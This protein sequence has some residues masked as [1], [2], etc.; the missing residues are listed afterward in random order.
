MYKKRIWGLN[1]I[2]L[3]L[4]LLAFPMGHAANQIDEAVEKTMDN[5]VYGIAKLVGASYTR[6]SRFSN[7][8][9]QWLKDNGYQE[10]LKHR[11]NWSSF[12]GLEVE[13][14]MSRR[15]T[16]FIH[17]NSDTALGYEE[18]RGELAQKFTGW[19]H[20]LRHFEGKGVQRGEMFGITVG[21]AD[22]NLAAL[23]IHNY[24]NVMRIRMLIHAVSEYSKTHGNPDGKVNLVCHSMGNTL[25]LK[26][27]L[28]GSAVDLSPQA[29]AFLPDNAI[30][31]AHLRELELPDGETGE[32]SN[33]VEK[34]VGIAGATKGLDKCKGLPELLI[35]T[36]RRLMGLSPNS[37]IIQEINQKEFIPAKKI[38]SIYGTNDHILE[39]SNSPDRIEGVSSLVQHSSESYIFKG[40]GHFQV[41][42]DHA[43]LVYSI[44]YG[45]DFLR[46]VSNWTSK[47]KDPNF[48]HQRLK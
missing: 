23:Q 10:L 41:K 38:F 6:S 42:D 21:D 26:A 8:F 30:I 25:A 47:F 32:I 9:Q 13:M 43:D 2:I 35:P 33:R 24:E 18:I 46:R 37:H 12:G 7:P 31:K 27:I 14:R 40:E 28:G 1:Y 11:L 44:L 29:Y 45:N 19:S 15:P 20:Y 4:G 34:F 22:S 16:I 36:C 17:G 48:S 3:T 5:C 39:T